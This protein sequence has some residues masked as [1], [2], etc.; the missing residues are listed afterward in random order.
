MRVQFEKN[1]TCL[2]IRIAAIGLLTLT[3]LAQESGVETSNSVSPPYRQADLPVDKRVSDLIVRMTVEEK[4]RQ[5]DMYFG[6]KELLDQTKDQTTDH[7]THA[8]PD[9][10][11]DPKNAEKKL[12]NLGVGS[13][14]DLY[15]S[16][17]LYNSI[18]AW[19]INSSRLGIP[20]LFLEEGLH[21]YMGN[22]QTVFPQ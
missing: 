17:R 11:F 16:G 8:K 2:L 6:C 22:N 1:K 7:H 3:A 15:P 12:G 21:G 20:A 9:A 19:V 13:I 14:H 5:L 10:V 18:Q 4:G